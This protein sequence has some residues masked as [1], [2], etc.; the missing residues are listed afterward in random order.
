MPLGEE[1]DEHPFDQPV[2][3]DDDALD[4]E[5]RPLQGV[6]LTLQATVVLGTGGRLRRGVGTGGVPL[7]GVLTGIPSG[8]LRRPTR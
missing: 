8:A 6:H 2:L 3:T 7:W 5:D 4:L 1:A